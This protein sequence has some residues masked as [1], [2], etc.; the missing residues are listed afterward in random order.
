MTVAISLAVLLTLLSAL[1]TA[2]ATA[3]YSVGGSRLRTLVEEG[4]RGATQLSEIRSRAGPLQGILFLFSSLSDLLAV[5]LATGTATL[6]WGLSGLLFGLPVSAFLVL[7]FGELLPRSF[8]A[9][10]SIRVALAV[11]PA[12]RAVE[13]VARPVLSPLL[14]LE[15]YLAR[16]AGEEGVTQEEREVREITSLGQREGVVG[17]EEHQ[18]VERAFRLDELS[19]WD[20]MTPRVA[21]FAWKDSLTLEEIVGE[22]EDVPYS[23]VPVFGESVDD[24]TGV[25]YVREAYQSFIA[26]RGG[27]TL[28]AV[29]RDPFFIPGSLP[30]TNLLRDFQAR[31]IHMGIVADEFGGT[32]GLVT[33]E[34]VLEELVGEIEDETDLPGEPLIR[35]S[36]NEFIASGALDLREINFALHVSLPQLEHRSL[37]GFIVEELGFVPQKGQTLERHGVR[38]DVV[39]ASETQVIR[40]RVRKLFSPGSHESS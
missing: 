7:L 27:T 1:S 19:V 11:A 30:L 26:G 10:R 17:T 16:A 32:D 40:A 23:R 36:R 14:R 38:I 35:I 33:L 34:D 9:R 12:V 2:S 3:I 28:K 6:Q 37:N 8:A 18:L 24:I 15:G 5:G 22:M 4:F 25:L 31:R 20:I 39:D 29:A 13:R 21:I